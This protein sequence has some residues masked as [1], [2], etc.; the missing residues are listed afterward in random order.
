[1]RALKNFPS[2]S[3]ISSMLTIILF[4]IVV[5]S[6]KNFQNNSFQSL[7]DNVNTTCDTTTSTSKHV[8]TCSSSTATV[9]YDSNFDA[10]SPAIK[11]FYDKL[12]S[13]AQNLYYKYSDLMDKRPVFTQSITTATFSLISDIISQT[14]EARTTGMPLSLDIVRFASFSIVGFV[15]DGPFYHY[16]YDLMWKFD[17][18]LQTKQ[19]FSKFIATSAQVFV[20]QTIG[21]LIYFPIYF[22]VYDIIEALISGRIPCLAVTG[23]KVRK[24]LFGVI[25]VSYL[26]F[27]LSNFLNFYFM[28]KQFRIIFLNIVDLFYSAYL[29]SK[30]A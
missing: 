20:D 21:S 14:I 13:G 26:V 18:Y 28:P 19:D 4:L 1:M 9:D 30:V 7:Q 25:F 15:Y 2:T 16:W 29:C 6:V 22:Y 3:I 27:P 24:E 12:T 23:N 17:D 5:P 8:P 10:P 11:R